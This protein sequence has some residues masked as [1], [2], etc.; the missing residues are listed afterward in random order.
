MKRFP[1]TTHAT[2]RFLI[3]A[4]AAAGLLSIAAPA[5]AATAYPMGTVN[6]RSGPSTQ[7]SV[8]TTISDG[9]SALVLDHVGDWLKVRTDAGV[10]GWMADWVTRVEADPA[11]STTPAPAPEPPTTTAPTDDSG[12]V[13]LVKDVQA[14]RS[15]SIYSGRSLDYDWLAPVRAWEHLTY[16]DSAEG[17]MKV[18]NVNGQRG[19]ID[20][21]RVMLTDKNVDFT[22]RAL[23]EAREGDWAMSFLKVREVVPGGTGLALR[24]GPS[25][26]YGAVATL[27]QG[28]PMKLLQ[29]PATEYVQA[30]L[31]DGTTGWVSRNWLKPVAVLPEETVRLQ[32]VSRGVLRLEVKGQ[33]AAVQ[34]GGGLLTLTLPENAA[35]NAYL[36]V[37]QFGVTDMALSPG[38]MTVGFST[39]FRHQI[40]SQA[41][42]TMVLEIRPV[43]EQ[44]QLVQGTDRV[45]Y[46][47]QMGGQVEPVIRQEGAYVALDLF[48]ARLA[49]GLALPQGLLAEADAG[50]VTFRVLSDKA[51]ALKRRGDILDLELLN[52]GLLGKTVVVD[53][54]HGGVET[55]AIGPTGLQEKTANLAIGLKLKALLE[56][57]GAKVVMSRTTDTRC[58]TPAELAAG[59]ALGDELHVDLG[60]RADLSDRV[61]AD[62]FISIHNN[63]SGDYA[64]R[65]TETY[66]TPDN[67]NA[68]QSQVL[69]SLVQAELVKT[70]GLRNLGVKQNIFY[71]TRYT[72]APAV[73][74]EIAFI[75]NSTEEALLRQDSF[76]T[77]TAEAL[78]RGIARLWD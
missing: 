23:Y 64:V 69:A 7:Y 10:V 58:A 74:A 19:W 68:S 57:A 66:W 65:G 67:F 16:L 28:T 38:S 44:V 70:L 73:L 40:V 41:N 47:L 12:L 34:A 9:E 78:F 17:W 29:I 39:A 61:G 59:A 24:S 37:G 53:P 48:G 8:I 45:T 11:P 13:R 42:G 49:A 50:G 46:R 35:R 76:L 4:I 6:V 56:A 51:F 31:A 72:D 21:A 18:A 75:S 62:A 14:V 30:M 5:F 52:P 20:G 36:Q 43:V 15:T 63:A 32:Q 26:G 22:R 71:V 54:G 77:K 2:K 33:V 3:S 1:T 27:A 25:A 60:C 55:G